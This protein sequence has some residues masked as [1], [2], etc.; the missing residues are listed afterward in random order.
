MGDGSEDGFAALTPVGTGSQ[1]G[2]LQPFEH[3]VDGF[4]LPALPVTREVQSRKKETG[5]RSSLEVC[6]LT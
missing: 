2:A 1:R 4:G 5:D 3:A 6:R